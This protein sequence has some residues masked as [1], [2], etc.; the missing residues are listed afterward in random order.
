MIRAVLS[1]LVLLSLAA[2]DED[3][4]MVSKACN[5]PCYAGPPGTAGNGPCG[6]G[7]TICDEND[8][9]VSC[10]GQTLP[11]PELC[12]QIDDDCDGEIDN[13][14][15]EEWAYQSCGTDLGICTAGT[16]VCDEGQR[17]CR[18]RE[19]GMEEVCNGLDDDCDG[20]VDNNL[21]L[22]FCYTGDPETL[23]F[24]ECRAG[25][26][27]CV[28]AQEMCL[29][30]K[31]PTTEICD[32]LDNDCDGLVDE[33]LSEKIDI[34]FVIDGSGSMASLFDETITTTHTIAGVMTDT[35]TRFGAAVFPG[36]RHEQR[37]FGYATM[38]L[39][40]DLVDGTTFQGE[41][42]NATNIG[43]GLEPGID[44]I[45]EVCSSTEINWRQDTEKHLLIFTDEEPQSAQSMALEEATSACL[46]SGII[47]HAVIKPNYVTEYEQISVPTGGNIFF[48]GYSVWMISDLLDFFSTNCN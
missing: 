6:V 19:E 26:I 4:A 11:V 38:S 47:V 41:I 8:I 24:G 5:L 10:Q 35:E 44:A 37:I 23:A 14:L 28:N 12:N 39:V 17:V 16:E 1:L 7:V 31:T 40:T 48:L 43:G 34:F 27:D 29:H 18:G 2:C 9:V 42:I 3:I 30:Q 33:D 21:S 13:N 36:P 46:A 22:E 15:T 20:L 45:H 25:V 32:G